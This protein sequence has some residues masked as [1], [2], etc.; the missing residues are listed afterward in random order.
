MALSRRVVWLAL[1]V[2]LGCGSRANAQSPDE[3]APLLRDSLKGWTAERASP[4]LAGG[5]LTLERGWMTLDKPLS[6]FV[7]T[8]DVRSATP[9]ARGG[10]VVRTWR[11][12]DLRTGVPSSAYVIVAAAS[13]PADGTLGSIVEYGEKGSARRFA[14]A[15][16]VGIDDD[17]IGGGW[18]RYEIEYIDDSIKV[19][20]DGALAGHA[21]AVTNVHGRFGFSVAAGAIQVRNVALREL[22]PGKP[23]NGV[24][25]ARKGLLPRVVR[26][27]KPRYTS[28]ALSHRIQGYVLVEAVV[29]PQGSPTGL[30]IVKSLDPTYGLDQE[31]LKAASNWRFKPATIDGQPVPVLIMIELTFTLRR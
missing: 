12:F 11:I 20:V 13:Q 1:G 22:D 21:D 29:D 4:K 26:E 6:S 23:V 16:R 25:L 8:M 15:S 2:A 14:S 19:S 5:I 24:Y 30:R 9:E 17:A 28:D 27:V 31:A 10:I 7:A 18:H 3:F